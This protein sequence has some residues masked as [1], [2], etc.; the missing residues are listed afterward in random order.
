V[1]RVEFRR[2]P[3]KYQRSRAWFVRE[4]IRLAVLGAF[5]G[6]AILMWGMS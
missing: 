4:A 3:A 1:I 2:V 5:V 6:A